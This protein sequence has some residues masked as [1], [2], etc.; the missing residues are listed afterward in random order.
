MLVISGHNLL[1][2]AKLSDVDTPNM[3]ETLAWYQKNI[4]MRDEFSFSKFG[5]NNRNDFFAF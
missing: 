1:Q 4:P 3:D 5:I 2:V